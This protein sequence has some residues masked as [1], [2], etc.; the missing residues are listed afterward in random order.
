MVL[1]K[2]LRFLYLDPQAAKRVINRAWL[3]YLKTSDLTSSDTLSPTSP[4][5]L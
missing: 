4:Y 1:E 3:G 2:E 5:V